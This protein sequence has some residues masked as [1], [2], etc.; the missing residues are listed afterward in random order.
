MHSLLIVYNTRRLNAGIIPR[1]LRANGLQYSVVSKQEF[2]DAHPAL[3]PSGIIL[4][5]GFQTLANNQDRELWRVVQKTERLIRDGRSIFGIC[6]GAQI[7]AKI[8]GASVVRHPAGVREIGYHAVLKSTPFTDSYIP[9]GL[10]YHWHYDIIEGL[11]QKHVV[12]RSAFTPIQAFKIGRHFGIQFHPEITTA[13]LREWLTIGA[14]RLSDPGAQA[15]SD[16][17]HAHR[18]HAIQNATRLKVAVARWS[19]LQR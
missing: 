17:I 7:L 16:Q 8:H 18:D 10:Y 19:S 5:G 13:T 12:L 1:I 14:H 6:L 11:P 15:A 3:I 9:E 2:L 4:L